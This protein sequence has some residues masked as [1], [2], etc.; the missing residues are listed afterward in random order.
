MNLAQPY[1]REN[2]V[3]FITD[4]LPDDFEEEIKTI[5]YTHGLFKKV[6]R[7]GHCAETLNKIQCFEILHTSASDAHF[8][9]TKIV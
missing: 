8:L 6:I 1:N 4:F 9:I 7:L 3:K 5:N 2:F